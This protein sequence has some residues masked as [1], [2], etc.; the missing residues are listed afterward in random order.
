MYFD[1]ATDINDLQK[2]H[3]DQAKLKNI[4]IE[5]RFKNFEDGYVIKTDPKRMNQVLLNLLNNAIKF[6]DRDGKIL[7]LVKTIRRPDD[8]TDIL[9]ISVTDSGR[10]IKKRHRNKLFKLFS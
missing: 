5:T 6:T 9:Q 8:L 7:I 10:G 2:I 4:Q 1:I 3:R